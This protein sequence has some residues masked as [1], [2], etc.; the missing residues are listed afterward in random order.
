[1]KSRHL[2]ILTVV[3]LALII[4][5]PVSAYSISVSGRTGDSIKSPK[6]QSYLDGIQLTKPQFNTVDTTIKSGTNSIVS[7][8]SVSAFT[9]GAY[10][11][12]NAVIEFKQ[13]VSVNGVIHGFS[14]SASFDSGVFR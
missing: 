9:N 5:A 3:V 14:Y 1:M 2:I 8:G 13:S 7:Q 6:F 10:N 4:A 12:E 11:Y